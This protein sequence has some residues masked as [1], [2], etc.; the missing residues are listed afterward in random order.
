[1]ADKLKTYIF[2]II[3]NLSLTQWSHW[4]LWPPICSCDES[5]YLSGI[6]GY[7]TSLEEWWHICQQSLF[8]FLIQVFLFLRYTFLILEWC[9]V[10]LALTSDIKE[11]MYVMVGIVGMWGHETMVCDVCLSIFLWYKN[12]YDT[13]IMTKI[14]WRYFNKLWSG[15]LLVHTVCLFCR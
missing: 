1:M 6:S 9:M 13:K 14:G 15:K 7:D 8:R 12:S 5:L 10:Q 2:S 3:Q 4:Y 11:K